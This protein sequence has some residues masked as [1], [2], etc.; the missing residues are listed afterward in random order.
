[1]SVQLCVDAN[2]DE[3]VDIVS[4]DADV[5]HGT[6]AYNAVSDL[7]FQIAQVRIELDSTTLVETTDEEVI[8][9]I[10]IPRI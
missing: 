3:L 9:T 8:I 1:M 6:D 2:I 5:E 7:A 10:K 4:E